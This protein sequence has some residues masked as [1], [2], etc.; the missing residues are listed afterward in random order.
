[1]NK[2][3]FNNLL[4]NYDTNLLDNLRGFGS[5]EEFL[6]FYVPGTSLITSFYNLIDALIEAQQ[7]EFII[8]YKKE[9]FNKNFYED[10]NIFLKK[11]AIH[12]E[13]T[14]NE[15]YNLK[16]KIDQNLYENFQ[17]EKRYKIEELNPI[18]IDSK[19]KV[20]VFKS[21]KKINQLY[22]D[23]LHKVKSNDF[24]S[25][26]II[27][28][29]NL[30]V[31]KIEK[32]KLFFV[33]KNRIIVE[34]SHNCENDKTLRKLLNIFFD[35][36]INN[37]I[38]EVADHAV[39]YLEEKIRIIDNKLIKPGIILP[40]HAGVYFDDLNYIIRKVF[41]E[42]TLKNTIDFGINKNY[43]KKSYHW[44]NLSE[45]KKIEKIDLILKE[46]VQENNLVDQSIVV[47]SIDS[48]FKINLGVNKDFKDLQLKK[49]ILLKIE[50]R[51]KKLDD[52]LEVF[53]DE[54]LDK[55]KLRLKNSP[56]TKL[57]N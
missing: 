32:S 1:M 22:L 18:K 26:K 51:L 46:I 6:K 28:N 4:D 13:K 37:N 36:C 48:N 29:E 31:G 30:F 49:N 9:S 27:K 5:E 17:K 50:I 23:I 39:I 7:L 34:I 41:K 38:Q 20:L 47:Q 52:T 12:E 10:V 35:I 55:N 56:Q 14:D 57:L 54:V 16:I 19:N 45:Q 11:I 43:F 44:I 21:E 24:F 33:I 42:Y 15:F 3:D 8:Y 2:I 40:S 25:K 53:V